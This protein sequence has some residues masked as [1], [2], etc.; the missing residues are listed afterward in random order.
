MLDDGGEEI[1]GGK[2]LEVALDLGFSRE[3]QMTVSVGDSIV[4][5][6]GVTAFQPP[7]RLAVRKPPLQFS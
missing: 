7:E 4:I 1:G 3:R 6:L 2:D 5:Y